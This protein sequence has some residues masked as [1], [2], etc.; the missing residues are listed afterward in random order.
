MEG[1]ELER[2]EL[3]LGKEETAWLKQRTVF[4]AGVGGVG[5]YAVEGLARTGIGHLILVDKDTVDITNLNR[6]IIALRSTVGRPKVEVA[7]ERIRDI[8]PACQVT[9]HR[10]F[11]LPEN[12]ETIDLAAMD[13]VVDCID[14]M[15]AKLDI[16]R[17][18]HEHGIPVISSMGTARKLQPELLRVSDITKTHTDPL[19]RVLRRKLREM[20]ISHLKCVWSTEA[21]CPCPP[22][23]PLPSNA[24]VPATAGLLLGS[25]VV[26]DLCSSIA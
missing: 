7:A 15:T 22:D 8:N 12:A 26:R 3:L 2:V 14:T 25:E 5:S 19:A 17:R 9:P 18:C 11:Y 1:R 21:P 4:V 6:Q 10:M 24:F 23:A 20:G 13:Y 16:V